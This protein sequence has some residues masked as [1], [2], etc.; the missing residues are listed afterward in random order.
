[1]GPGLR[2]DDVGDCTFVRPGAR[3]GPFA[4]P[5]LVAGHGD[6]FSEPGSSWLCLGPQPSRGTIETGFGFAAA[7]HMSADPAARSCPDKHLN[8]QELAMQKHA[9]E[10]KDAKL[11]IN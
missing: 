10:R 6:S 7:L 1:M 4:E 5:T 3:V 9:K 11:A 8:R 2:R